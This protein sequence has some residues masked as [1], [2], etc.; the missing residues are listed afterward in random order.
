MLIS[1]ACLA[2]ASWSTALFA[3]VHLAT[4]AP[5]NSTENYGGSNVTREIGD[6]F[7]RIMPLGASIT[8]G[9]ESSQGNGYRKELRDQLRFDGWP[10]NM[11][12][13]LRSGAMNDSVCNASKRWSF[14]THSCD[15]TMRDGQ[16]SSS[17]RLWRGHKPP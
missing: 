2:F 6:F 5:L 8:N 3:T 14:K 7:L 9:L 11:V 4:S 13:T 15:R 17:T 16:A 1:Q 12:G 10:V